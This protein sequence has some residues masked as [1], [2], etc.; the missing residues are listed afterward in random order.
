MA[1][2]LALFALCGFN[3]QTLAATD[4][5]QGS[6][7][8]TDWVTAANWLDAASAA[9]VSGDS[10]IFSGTNY[11]SSATL[12]D[13]LTNSSFAIAG[14]TFNAGSLA[15]S[16]TGNAFELTG[17]ITNNGSNA[18]KIANAVVLSGTETFTTTAGGGNIVISGPISDGGTGQGVTAAGSG[19]L[20]LSGSNSY[21]G[22]TT[23]TGGALRLVANSTNTVGGVTSALSNSS[24]ELQLNTGSTLQLLGNTTNTIFEPA[25]AAATSTTS[26]VQE[27][28]GGAY[29]F[30]VGN[31][32][33]TASPTTLIL[34]NMGVLGVTGSV[35]Y[36]YNV[37][38]ATGYTLQ[39]GSGSAG[40]GALYFENNETFNV[41]N[42]G[43]TMSV[44]G[45]FNLNYAANN[46]YTVSFG[47]QG[48]YN[49]GP[50][51]GLSGDTFNVNFD[52]TGT[53]VLSTPS[54]GGA[55]TV[56]VNAGTAQLN[57]NASGAPATNILNPAA[58]LSLSGGT[59]QVIGAAAGGTS[60][61]FGAV[62]AGIG[63][64]VISA[65]PASGSNIPTVTLGSFTQSVGGSM[66]FIGPATIGA[67][68][69]AVP[70]TATI[71]TTTAGNG[72]ASN[73]GLLWS[74]GTRVG[75]ATVGLYDWA[76]TD[77]TAGAAGTSPYTI[78]GGS[79]VTGFYTNVASGGTI[80]N[81]DLNDNL[82]G[83]AKAANVGGTGSYKNDSYLDTI[84]FNVAGAYT[85][86]TTTGGANGV[87][88][89]GGILVTPNVG[90]N[91]TTI[92]SGGA[93]LSPAYAAGASALDVYQ[94]DTAGQLDFNVP[95]YNSW[96][97][98]NFNSV[99]SYVQGGPGTV[100]LTGQ[101]TNDG[102]TGA[103]YLNGGDTV[104]N[105]DAQL[106]KAVTAAALVL[107]GGTVVANANTT[108]DNG[109]GA[110]PRPVTV[111]GNGGGLAAV[112]G[113]TLTVDGV[114]GS[115]ATG[116]GPVIIGIPASSANGNTVGLVP[117]TGTGTA[118]TTAVYAN[119]TVMLTGLNTYSGGT[120]LDSGILN[121]SAL[122]QIGG[123]NYGGVILNG[124]TLQY[125]TG[126]TVDISSGPVTILA[127]GGTIDV[128]G[129]AVTYL[130]AIGNGGTG[131]LTVASTTAGGSLTLDGIN[132]FTGGLTDN[133][134]ATVNLD[135]PS[136]IAGP[137]SVAGTLNLS[138][139]ATLSNPASLTL[140]G[141]A[142]LNLN[143]QTISTGP[144]SGTTSGAT[145]TSS[146]GL[147]GSLTV[148]Q[149]GATNTFAGVISGSGFSF[150]TSGSGTTILTGANTYTGT[151]T[152]G[153]TSTLQVNGPGGNLGAGAIT[154]SGG[155]LNVQGS[156]ALGGSGTT[157][158]LSAGS[159]LSLLDGSTNTV[160]LAGAGG[161][162]V[163]L[164]LNGTTT[165]PDTFSVELS[166]SGGSATGDELVVNSG[167]VAF[168][169]SS[170]DTVIVGTGLSS[171][172]VL[173]S[174]TAVPI[175]YVPNGTLSLSD[176]TIGGT[177]LVSIG[178][179][180]TAA[181]YREILA[182]INGPSG[183]S[184]ELVIDL[185][186]ALTNFYWTG[187]G[188]TT[189]GS[190]TDLS[191]FATSH[192]G[193]T[194]VT[195]A[196][197]NGAA[198]IFLTADSNLS[199]NYTENLNGVY[200]VNSLNFTGSGSGAASNSVTLAPGAAGSSN[201]L[202]LDPV[203]AY[204]NANSG[205]SYAAGNGLA[206]EAGS[207]A[208]TITANI[209]LAD[210]QTWA[211]NNSSANPLTV[212]GTIGNVSSAAALTKTGPGTLILSAANT[213]SGGTTIYG[214]TLQLGTANALLSTAALIVSGT[215]SSA[216]TLDLHGN[217][218][219]VGSLSDGG[220]SVGIITDSTGTAALTDND[221]AS[222]SYG[223]TLT[224]N[225][226]GNSS[227][228]SV[229]EAGG[230][231]LKLSG[232]NNFNGAAVVTSGTL[233]A[234][235][236]YAFGNVNSA[237]G[238]LVLNPAGANT[239]VAVF[240]S[241]T[242]SIASL[243]GTG[244]V[245]LGNA[246]A[247]TPTILAI[248]GAAQL[249]GTLNGVISDVSGSQL[250][251]TGSVV[252]GNGSLT[253]NGANTFTGTLTV[254]NGTLT[255]NNTN[256]FTGV[257]TING[258]SLLL[259]NSNAVADSAVNL[260]GGTLGVTTPTSVNIAALEGTSNLS[261][262]NNASAAVAL[263][264]NGTSGTWVDTGLIT[265]AGSVTLSNAGINEQ[266]GNASGVGAANYSGG[267]TVN[268]GSLTI[269]GTSYQTGPATLNAGTLIL[270]GTSTVTGAVTLSGNG[271]STFT[272]ENSAVVTSANAL[273]TDTVNNSY[274][275]A[276]VATL[277]NN[278]SVTVAGFSWGNGTDRVG[279]GNSLTIENTASLIDNG[280]FNFMNTDGGTSNLGLVTYNLS[281]GTL[282]AQNF[283][284]SN[285]GGNAGT[286]VTFNLNGGTLEPLAADGANGST[287]F[288][289]ALTRLAASVIAGGA[290]VNT[291]G[292]NITIGQ[293]LVHGGT[294]TDGGLTVEGTG[295][296]TLTGVNT[297]NGTTTINSGATLQLGNGTTGNDGTITASNGIT[298]NGTLIYNRF[299][300][301]TS[302][303]VI[304]GTGNVTKTGLGTQTLSA[305]N[306]YTGATTVSGG[307][308]IVSGE[309]FGTT[310]AAVSN[311]STLDLTDANAING[312]AHLL[313]SAGTL[314]VA[315]QLNLFLGDL[316]VAIGASTLDIG[317]SGDI[318]NFLDSSAN[319]WTGTLAITNWNGN[320]ADLNGGGSDQILFTEENGVTPAPLTLAQLSDISFVDPT[321]DG[322][323][324][325]TNLG[326]VQLSDG[327]IVAA[328]IPEPGT[329][330][331][332]LA[333]AG[334]LCFWKR[335]RRRSQ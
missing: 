209:E 224:D 104:I 74:N 13:S 271:V 72:P 6:A 139:A 69:V 56:S 131:G 12:T 67:S 116:S 140:V 252:L 289:P 138:S 153:G 119:G 29:N 249:S 169:G 202:I 151:T 284:L 94:N 172:A 335:S 51:T 71:T 133:V 109:A 9:P 128:N 19:I 281:G 18:E 17:G 206:V 330:A 143:G 212:S 66:E 293:A 316:T 44:P 303:V 174:G 184:D 217:N 115:A 193:A 80:A 233:I 321:I 121:F 135:G 11:S 283:I 59:L 99:G 197:I 227:T 305:D 84:R 126:N 130:N 27:F 75:I 250:A 113:D 201:Y 235:N 114:I 142:A 288:F 199:T 166:S 92:A 238:G 182:V 134:G 254:N 8:S 157:L 282:A 145:I 260:Q 334:I 191:N 241:S 106:G 16:F 86:T 122:S 190:W 5:W 159:T 277:E 150:A 68:N 163:S 268:G 144:F 188:A 255:L 308:L 263:N 43:V 96:S 46:F 229:V 24:S 304:S 328:A 311:N 49:I 97:G 234:A 275:S 187:K 168:A 253:L 309:L 181:S 246:A 313:L 177:G 39:L 23:V 141:A 276:L 63:M 262:T 195:G 290:V 331:M 264:I 20:R 124:G 183:T 220:V 108:L 297:Y 2:I 310:S 129:N 154:V 216:G 78:I 123:A 230:G 30:Y 196:S 170:P 245:V 164:T 35:N 76:S 180:T 285:Y 171:G 239:P 41:T 237:T 31:D 189:A 149:G 156:L 280:S 98:A 314:E 85:F 14:I 178:S 89:V 25:T 22:A 215:G 90:A 40:T 213:Y 295:V 137:V 292:F 38:G 61:T 317:A 208:H 26:G 79:Q 218:Q 73:F 165:T 37:G 323:A 325:N 222:D 136:A 273:D 225:N 125:A 148:N 194:P 274:S 198:N 65:A 257:T 53:V 299:G 176:F 47:G 32:G 327:E 167:T 45:G 223:G 301:P 77:T 103:T 58:T 34:G 54:G 219:T 287:L 200:T 306:T 232:S 57:F 251:A 173:T 91:N 302:A 132:T 81:S 266:F 95:F 118:N 307:T 332:M 83:S 102:Q 100:V 269:S 333:G 298:D 105:N 36:A 62:T 15:Y 247:G 204:S 107:N 221:S 312:N 242:P 267:T 82:L 278:A 286:L 258:G 291:N 231:S 147:G 320:G 272:V 1:S 259:G 236:N 55:G 33:G 162:N 60:Q 48:N 279:S 243:T 329:W 192:T 322:V 112:T 52:T 152:V 111:E 110:N 256:T 270:A 324:Y 175:L 315:A 7:G 4:T 261:L 210:N 117:G 248:G 179:G 160:T 120:E 244:N 240:T 211:I 28:G 93:Y 326:A 70:A 10:L 203:T 294:G 158:G 214:G 42:P 226:A 21:S 155:T 186:N 87:S 161:S 64:D 88:E 185:Q 146:N 101:T 318:L 228:L 300:T 319:T 207:D 127:P 3:P 205:A 296:L 265:G 50:F